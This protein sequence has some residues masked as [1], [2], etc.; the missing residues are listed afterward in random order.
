MYWKVYVVAPEFMHM[1]LLGVDVTDF[2]EYFPNQ[3][4]KYLVLADLLDERVKNHDKVYVAIKYGLINVLK[5]FISSRLQKPTRST[6]KHGT[7][8]DLALI[9]SCKQGHLQ[10]AKIFIKEGANM[11]FLNQECLTMAI[12]KRHFHIIDYL[13]S[14]NIPIW[15]YKLRL[16]K[17]AND[18]EMLAHLIKHRQGIDDTEYNQEAYYRYWCRKKYWYREKYG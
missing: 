4:K 11:N 6:I 3:S 9:Q 10:M 15:D 18:E 2:E 14:L 1:S 8:D 16:A 7:W 13:V 5:H 17:Q 12:K